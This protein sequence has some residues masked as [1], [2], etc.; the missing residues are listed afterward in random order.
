MN[1]VLATIT[2]L[3]LVAAASGSAQTARQP[4]PCV[5]GPIPA[6]TTELRELR[7][8]LGQSTLT[9][10]RLELAMARMQVQ[11]ERVLHLDSQ[12]DAI[13]G[14]RAQREDERAN[15]ASQLAQFSTVLDAADTVP[16]EDLRQIQQMLKEQKSRLAQ[17]DVSIQ[18]L[19]NDETDAQAALADGQALLNSI[20]AGLTDLERSLGR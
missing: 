20:N 5:A 17:L 10:M 16:P 7:E 13:A 3:G 1:R 15:L 11:Q 4:D 6:L 14:R 19:R 2:L 8:D 12:R 9:R 18:Q